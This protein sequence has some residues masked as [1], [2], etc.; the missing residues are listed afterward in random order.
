MITRLKTISLVVLT[1]A[2]AGIHAQNGVNSPYSRYGF[3]VMSD[4]SMGFNKGMG[5]IS[6]GFRDGQSINTANPASYSGCDSLTAL[7]DFGLSL[8]NGNY[9]MNGLQQNARNTSF[10]YAAFHFRAYKGVGV[11]VA[12]LPVTNI[13]YSFSSSSEVLSGSEDITSSYT[14][15]G[16]GGLHQVMLGAGFQIAKPLS[17]GA[18]I[19]YLYGDYTHSMSMSFS[20]SS[21]NSITR[22]YTAD[23]STYSLDLG[24]Q[25][26]QVL[27]KDKKLVVGATYSL[28]HD[29]NNDAY[30]STANYNSSSST[31][32]T[33]TDTIKNAFQLP[34]SI[35]AGLAYY[36]KNNIVVGADVMVQKWSDVRFPNQATT[37]A[38]NGATDANDF[39]TVNNIFNDYVKLSAGIAYTPDPMARSYG[40]RITYKFGGFYSKTYANT[41]VES[42]IS[43]KPYE[44]GVSAGLTL[45]ISNRN[46]MWSS[47]KINISMQW[48]HTNVPYMSA[49]MKSQTDLTENY[50]KLS[51]GLTFSD[52]WFY[53]WKVK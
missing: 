28:G 13:G 30:R 33:N 46:A 36:Y 17:V 44:F 16:S 22:S 20:E 49:T 21:I 12:V 34:T 48:V 40:Q 18:N 10:D 15:S 5:G 53:K 52:R 9:K 1:A 27:S 26:T 41:D 37:S 51:V 31:T 7:F 50:L 35:T 43:G 8:Q 4:R 25:Y 42:N 3:G 38:S 32:T 29:I 19:S 14:F 45:P 47:P 39:T 11:A 2:C 23:I 24:A 6:Q